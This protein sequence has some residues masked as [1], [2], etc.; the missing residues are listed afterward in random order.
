MKYVKIDW[1]RSDAVLLDELLPADDGGCTHETALADATIT[2][3]AHDLRAVWEE[4]PGR[5]GRGDT[6]PAYRPGGGT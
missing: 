6:G 2:V 3:H 1:M 5:A 4:A